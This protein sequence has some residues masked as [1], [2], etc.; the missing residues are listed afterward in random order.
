MLFSI[1]EA[2]AIFFPH[3]LTVNR[4]FAI[5]DRAFNLALGMG[6]LLAAKVSLDI[7]SKSPATLV[8]VELFNVL[9]VTILAVIRSPFALTVHGLCATRLGA[10]LIGIVI[11]AF[12]P[13]V[14]G[15]LRHLVHTAALIRVFLNIV[16]A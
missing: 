16:D 10:H 11:R 2:V 7:N 4:L 15:N 5:L 9:A 8:P 1:V 12:N 13:V 6:A 3:S 14:Q